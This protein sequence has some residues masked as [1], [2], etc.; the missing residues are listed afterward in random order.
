MSSKPVETDKPLVNRVAQSGLI[1][2]DLEKLVDYGE[3]SEFD[4]K[5]YL[6]EELILKEN[7]FREALKNHDWQQ[8]SGQVLLVFCSADAIIPTWAY[9]LVASF[10][11]EICDDV[12][13]GTRTSYLE[14]Q[15]NRM[16]EAMDITP[17]ADGRVIVKGCSSREVPQGAYVAL[18][19]KLRPHARSI[20][21]DEPCSTVPVYKRK[22]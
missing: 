9:M 14:M 19:H 8:Y 15:F 3:I 5:D 17:Y 11:G 20:V 16:I 12:V 22:R 10:A 13:Y 21:F 7:D 2:I 18:T 6:F 4:I 1:T